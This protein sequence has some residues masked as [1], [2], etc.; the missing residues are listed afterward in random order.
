MK[1]KSF[2]RENTLSTS[3]PKISIRKSGTIIINRDAVILTQLP[4]G[5]YIEIAQDQDSPKDWFININAGKEGF[6][7]RQ[8]KY[9]ALTFNAKQLS[10]KILDSIGFDHSASMIIGSEII[11]VGNHKYLPIITKSAK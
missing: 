5:G 11:T 6:I 4:L 3:G 9:D 1:L 8:T 7:L 2:N 10:D